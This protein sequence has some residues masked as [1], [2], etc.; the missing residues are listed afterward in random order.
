MELIQVQMVF[1]V[2]LFVPS[3]VSRKIISMVMVRSPV[4][5]RGSRGQL[6][7]FAFIGYLPRCLVNLA[8]RDWLVVS[9]LRIRAF[10]SI[11]ARL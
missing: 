4:G 5:P 11:L 10:L 6:H 3:L 2:G 8:F 7:E 1:P 9:C